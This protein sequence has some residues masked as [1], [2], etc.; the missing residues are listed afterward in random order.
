MMPPDPQKRWNTMEQETQRP[1]RRRTQTDRDPERRSRQRP[2]TEPARRRSAEPEPTRRAARTDRTQ[3]AAQE[4]PARRTRSAAPEATRRAN[5]ETKKSGRK[6]KAAEK[7]TKKAEKPKKEE[8]TGPS[9]KKRKPHRLRNTNFG[10]KFVTML[11]VVAA[12]VFGLVIF[13]K[14]QHIQVQGNAYYTADEIAEASGIALEDN[15]LTMS[16][17][18]VAARIRAELPYVSEVQI[19]RSLPNTVV[20]TVTEF[21]VTYGIQDEINRW[22]LIN[23]EGRVL[24]QSNAQAVKDHVI[25]QGLI[26]QSPEI[27]DDIKPA[28]TEGAD[29]SELASKKDAALTLLQLLETSA[30]AKQIVSIDVS[31]SYDILLWYGTQYQIKLGN[32]EQLAYKMQYL[33]AVLEELESFQSGVIDLTFTEDKKAHFQPFG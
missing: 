27:G 21:E 25:V 13:F 11:A 32:T 23:R 1:V 17:A 26:I 29:M 2:E 14:I 9:L 7:A 31:T 22:W 24:D 28:A 16:K 6:T 10:V 30:F 19:K 5:S 8:K 4:A 3:D 18:A 15:L 12:V 20:I 33:Q